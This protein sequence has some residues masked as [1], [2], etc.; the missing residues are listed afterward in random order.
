MGI[1]PIQIVDFGS[2]ALAGHPL[3]MTKDFLSQREE[4]TKRLAA[5]LHE[6]LILPDGG[7]FLGRT[8]SLLR[9][10]NLRA[11]VSRKAFNIILQAAKNPVDE[12]DVEHGESRFWTKRLVY[13]SLTRMVSEHN[14]EV[15]QLPG[16]VWCTWFKEQ[17]A[18][19]H[20]LAQKALRNSK[21]MADADQTLDYPAED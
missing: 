7:E 16:F 20:S 6:A 18:L 12:N 9:A 3:K 5:K 10:P 17:T 15:P 19:I 21:A 14:L 11:R 8:G 13:N 1:S 4:R 2:A